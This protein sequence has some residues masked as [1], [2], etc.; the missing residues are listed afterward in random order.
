MENEYI[1]S[2]VD[3]F[4]GKID[5]IQEN[6]SGFSQAI[7]ERRNKINKLLSDI[8]IQS[9]ILNQRSIQKKSNQVDYAV[10]EVIND[11]NTA[12]RKWNDALQS[13]LKGVQFIK[14]HEKYL[15]VMVFGAVKSGKS[16]LG[17]FFAASIVKSS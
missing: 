5:L 1:K 2:N 11:F 7:D 16:S 17:N 10:A 8:P 14:K 12:I 15:V 13:N 6:L 4:F 9:N 3:E